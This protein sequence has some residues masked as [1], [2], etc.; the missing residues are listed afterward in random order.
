M[1]LPPAINDEFQY[2]LRKLRNLIK[3]TVRFGPEGWLP[4]IIR[5][6]L[7]WYVARRNSRA[8]VTNSVDV[9]DFMGDYAPGALK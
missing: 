3:H 9:H 1:R 2:R 8:V 6:Q 4:P 7:D 5:P